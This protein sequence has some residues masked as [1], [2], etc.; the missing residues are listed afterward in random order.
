MAVDFGSLSIVIAIQICLAPMVHA[1][2]ELPMAIRT[3]LSHLTDE[4]E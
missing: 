4:L 3:C 1:L 2:L